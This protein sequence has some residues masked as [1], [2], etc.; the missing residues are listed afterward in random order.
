PA[1]GANPRRKDV[2]VEVDCLVATN[3][4]HCPRQDAIADVVQSFANAPVVN[5]DGTTGVQLHVDVGSLFG[6]GISSVPGTH[7]VIGTYGNFGGGGDQ[8]AEA[9]NEII[10]SFSKPK[11]G[12]TKFATLREAFFDSRRDLLFRYA[13]FGHQTNYRQVSDDCTSGEAN[14]TPGNEFMVTLGGNLTPT[15]PCW[16]ADANGFSVGS[17][18]E[19][20]GTFMHELGHT[21]GLHHGGDQETNDKPNYLSVMTYAFQG[22]NVPPSPNGVL[23]GGCDYSRIALPPLDPANLIE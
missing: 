4:S 17:A 3:H 22:C 13:I 8:I 5:L 12:V 6:A 19:Q 11:G 14:T 10:D 23:P 1:F 21:L 7:G 9:G 15:F 20:A 16:T 18:Q 2:F